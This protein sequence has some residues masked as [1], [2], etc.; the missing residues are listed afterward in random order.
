MSESRAMMTPSIES[1]AKAA[2]DRISVWIFDLDNTLYPAECDLF[3]QI[4]RRIGAF[5]SDLL[6]LDPGEARALQKRYF[7]EYGTTMRGLM[8]HHGVDPG[9]FLEYVHRIDHSPIPPS[10]DLDAALARLPGRRLIYTNASASH[11]ENVMDMLG[12]RARFER[13]FDIV[14]A[15][16]LPK[17]DP[18][19]YR[20]LVESA[21]FDPKTAVFVDDMPRNLEPAAAIGMTTVW[22][23]TNTEYA[24]QGEVGDHIHHITDNLL[25]WLQNVLAARSA[26]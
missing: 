3:S 1:G 12:V 21:E 26:G 17:P 15:N 4:D 20:R 25:D 13:I 10:P 16:Y 23:R 5:V 19:P 2:L 6:G 8:D 24:Q 7:R 14:A 9:V 22:L 11:A 18:E